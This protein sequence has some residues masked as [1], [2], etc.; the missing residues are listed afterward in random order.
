M[1]AA[2]PEIDTDIREVFQ[3]ILPQEEFHAHAFKVMAGERG[4][5]ATAN[6]HAAG[7][8]AIGLIPA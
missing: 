8:A 1:I 6:A 3:R 7:R 5:A 2:D 4:M